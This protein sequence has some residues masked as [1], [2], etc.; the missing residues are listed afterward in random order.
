MA[1]G[2]AG[3]AVGRFGSTC[4]HCPACRRGNVVH[5]QERRA[6]GPVVP[7]RLVDHADGS[8]VRPH[9]RPAGSVPDGGH[10]LRTRRRHGGPLRGRSVAARTSGR[11]HGAGARHRP[12]ATARPPGPAPR[13][14]DGARLILSTAACT[15]PSGGTG[16]RARAARAAHRPRLQRASTVTGLP[17]AAP[18]AP[19]AQ[20]FAVATGV[21]PRVRGRSA[22]GGAAGARPAVRG[23]GPLPTRS[24]PPPH[25]RHAPGGYAPDAVPSATRAKTRGMVDV[26]GATGAPTSGVV[27]LPAASPPSPGRRPPVASARV[28]SCKR[29]GG[30][31]G[32]RAAVRA[33]RDQR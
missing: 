30:G 32:Q 22:G 23:T 9:P 17:A 12:D 11:P 7:R 19:E 15:E 20:N 5:C 14:R 8:R 2:R 13:G 33:A 18:P 26:T 25:D 29:E 1:G 16:R 28:S 27:V 3:R 10:V 21:R 31:A 24:S 4:G 6:P